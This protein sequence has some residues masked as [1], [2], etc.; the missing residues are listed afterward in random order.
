MPAPVFAE[1]DLLLSQKALEELYRARLSRGLAQPLAEVLS[2]AVG[3]VR[4]Y[5]SRFELPPDRWRRLVRRIA[6]YNLLSF[7]G[8]TVPETIARDYEAALEELSG[9]RDGQFADLLPPA[10]PVPDAARRAA[11]GSRSW[12]PTRYAEVHP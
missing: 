6:V 9:I 10:A 3:L 8:G 7:P 5:T 12:I 11:W 1:A 4:D 2:E